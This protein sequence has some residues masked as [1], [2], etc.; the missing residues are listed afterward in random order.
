LL[1]FS[2]DPAKIFP[3]DATGLAVAYD[4]MAINKLT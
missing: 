2:K 3:P 4:R 1:S